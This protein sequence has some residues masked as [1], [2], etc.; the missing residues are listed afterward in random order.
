M[1]VQWASGHY[2]A[3]VRRGNVYSCY[4]AINDWVFYLSLLG[5]FL[6]ILFFFIFSFFFLHPNYL[7]FP[8][9]FFISFVFSLFSFLFL[10]SHLP[11]F[12]FSFLPVFF[13]S[14]LPRLTSFSSYLP[15]FRI[16]IFHALPSLHPSSFLLLSLPSSFLFVPSTLLS[17]DSH[18]FLEDARLYEWEKTY[19][20]LVGEEEEEEQENEEPRE[21]NGAE[22]TMG[23]ESALLHHTFR[24]THFILYLLPRHALPTSLSDP[25]AL[26]TTKGQRRGAQL[27]VKVYT[28]CIY[29]AAG[30][31]SL[32]LL[33]T[34]KPSQADEP[35]TSF[36]P[37]KCKWRWRVL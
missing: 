1:S 35:S 18:R 5:P 17:I 11:M 4:V 13:N 14:F 6:C 7:T 10:L 16:S 32:R 8:F 23:Q 21:V 28:R 33:Q 27:S 20:V 31:P 36:F 30:R 34:W 19:V 15:F 29:C 26:G 2:G 22:E 9:L 37:G 3:S 12:I 24:N 25:P